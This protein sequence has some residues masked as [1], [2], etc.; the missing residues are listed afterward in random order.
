MKTIIYIF[1]FLF[2]SFNS[3]AQNKTNYCFF[4]LSKN[5]RTNQFQGYIWRVNGSVL[6]HYDS[7]PQI[8]IT[9]FP[10][11]DT[12]VIINKKDKSTNQIITHFTPS[13][14]YILYLS[15]CEDGFDFEKKK[16]FDD[17][18][19]IFK[20]TADKHL[21]SVIVSKW[22]NANLNIY[23]SN[24]DTAYSYFIIYGADATMIGTR[25]SNNNWVNNIKPL[26]IFLSTNCETIHIGRF[27]K[28]AYPIENGRI[29]FDYDQYF[30]LEF[31]HISFVRVLNGETVFV[32]F[33]GKTKKINIEFK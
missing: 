21:D 17:Y 7:L 15:C 18:Q 26:R 2:I 4:E 20:T 9:H 23:S 19:D 16:V 32:R 28:G 6:N 25:L 14:T 11:N 8:V 10:Q 5:L 27:K 12:V 30:Y 33:N 31:L 1:L 22:P 24:L 3:F 13:E 29:A